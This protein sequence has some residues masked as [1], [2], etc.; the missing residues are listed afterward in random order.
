M[1]K[2]TDF[3]RV[4]DNVLPVDMCKRIITGFE[5]DKNHHINSGTGYESTGNLH[6]NAKNS[7]VPL[8]HC[9]L[10]GTKRY[11]CTSAFGLARGA[12]VCLSVQ[13]I[14]TIIPRIFAWISSL[15]H[16]D[17]MIFRNNLLIFF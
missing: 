14:D 1:N 8:G 15:L 11:I 9:T 13:R 12:W 3:I 2:L 7:L 16:H 4:Y 6:R 17:T 10:F 5:K